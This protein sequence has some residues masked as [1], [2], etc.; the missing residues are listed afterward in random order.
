MRV[1]NLEVD[2]LG[3]SRISNEQVMKM[4]TDDALDFT[5]IRQQPAAILRAHKCVQNI[6][7]ERE[8]Y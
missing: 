5:P 7:V 6:P 3:E 4:R 8:L 2:K 1:V